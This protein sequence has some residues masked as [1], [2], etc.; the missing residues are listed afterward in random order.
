MIRKRASMLRHSTLS[1]LFISTWLP[2]WIWQYTRWFKYDRDKLWLVYTQTVPVIFEPPCILRSVRRRSR[3]EYS[4]LRHETFFWRNIPNLTYTTSFSRFLNHTHTHTHTH[5]PTHTHT[6]THT[7][8]VGLLWASDQL[9][10]ESATY[11]RHD[12]HKIRIFTLS[13]DSNPRFQQSSG[14]RPKRDT[15][16][17]CRI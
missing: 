17:T 6:H 9:M 8:T 16:S 1:I 5:T 4:D 15:A 13:R 10:A 11:T 12:K 3:T 14:R 7:H 2:F